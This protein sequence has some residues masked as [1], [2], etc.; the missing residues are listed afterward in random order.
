M[1]QK[2]QSSRIAA[3]AQGQKER[4]INAWIPADDYL[5]KLVQAEWLLICTIALCRTF[6]RLWRGMCDGLWEGLRVGCAGVLGLAVWG[7]SVAYEGLAGW[8]GVG[9]PQ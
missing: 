8:I 5:L 1:Q 2:L 4:G 6:W 9:M 7:S 3:C